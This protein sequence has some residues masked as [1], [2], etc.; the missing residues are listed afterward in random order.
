MPNEWLLTEEELLRASGLI[1]FSEHGRQHYRMITQAQAR[2][3]VEWGDA[4]CQHGDTRFYDGTLKR[5]CSQCWAEFRKEA[6]L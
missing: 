5:Q 2:K 4:L 3:I 1:S 6:G